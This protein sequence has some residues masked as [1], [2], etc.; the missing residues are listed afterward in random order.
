MKKHSLHRHM[1]N[2]LIFN[3]PALY[4]DR[5][6]QLLEEARHH[7][8][9]DALLIAAYGHASA[10]SGDWASSDE[11]PQELRDCVARVRDNPPEWWRPLR[12]PMAGPL[13][14]LG[15]DDDDRAARH[16]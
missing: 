8:I 1:A 10:G 14:I 11:L 9:A 5:V 7:R 4:S 2:D 12:P 13:A 16:C 6:H 3:T 15:A